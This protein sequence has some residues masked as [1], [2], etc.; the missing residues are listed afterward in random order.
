MS[1]RPPMPEWSWRAV[2]VRWL[3]FADSATPELPLGRLLRLA[4]F[5]VT[6]GMAAVLLIGT[7]NRVMIVEL[8]IPAWVVAT[9]I[10]LPLVFAPL[11]MLVGHRSDTHRS[12]LGWR[13]TPYIWF[14]SLMQFGGLAIMPFALLLLSGDSH[15]PPIVGQAGAALAFLLAGAGLHTTQTAGLALATDLA[16]AH[17][18]PRVVALLCLM[19]LAGT[20]VS[21]VI[22]GVLLSPFSE[23]RLI[24][25]V[26]G[27]AAVSLVV[28]G[29]ALWKQEARDPNR[30]AATAPAPSFRE[31]WNAYAR[32]GRAGRRLVAIGFGTVSFSMQDVLL[33]PYGGKILH[34]PV[35]AT[36]GLTALLAL[37]GGAG[38]WLAARAL[39]RG[40]DAYR[41]AGFGA[42]AG[43]I[44]FASVIFAAPMGSPPLFIVGVAMVG[45]GG[46]L[47]AHG[48]LT[49]SMA[50]AKEDATGLAL[51]AWGA[52]QALAAGLAIAAGGILSD[53]IGAMGA[54]GRLGPALT[55]PAC[56]YEAVYL[57]EILLLF[58]TLVVIGPL[59]GRAYRE[60]GGSSSRY[61]PAAAPY[62]ATAIVGATARHGLK[63]PLGGTNVRSLSPR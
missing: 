11:R 58:T 61:A 18:R 48:T 13:R 19:L 55:G 12:V 37:G 28:N 39:G 60:G 31:A 53:A 41:V 56:G 4:L 29:V 7:L 30:F 36:T 25:V 2:G 16:P 44:A 1:E 50:M 6:V 45:F 27:A 52:V 51:G 21:A 8:G 38:L 26:Q 57:I 9:M 34:L 23:L 15:G 14:G 40:A 5:Q 62:A 24:Q 47:F 43:L 35:G 46:G 20:V 17:A 10:S 3:P 54:A 33:E 42:V 63:D 49:A 32:T 59:A 22:F